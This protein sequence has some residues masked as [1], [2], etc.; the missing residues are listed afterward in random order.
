M[1]KIN[2]YN[3]C[4]VTYETLPNPISQN[5][6][7]FLLENY[8]CN[9]LYIYHPML[10]MKEG[11]KLSSGFYLYRNNKLCKSEKAFHWKFFWPLLYIKDVL[12]T[13]FWCL[14]FNQKFDIYFASGNLN[15]L[16][17]I[18]LRKLGLVRRVVY[19]SLDYYPRRFNNSFFNWLYF[20]L[21]KFCVRF[22]DE[23][24]NVNPNIVQA[25]FNKMGMDPKVFDKQYTVPGSIWFYKT[26]RLPFS[27]IN[28]NKIVYRGTL[29]DFMGIDLAIKAMP[30]ILKKFPNLIFEI[31]G[32]GIDKERLMELTRQ[33]NVSRNVIFHGFVKGRQQMEKVLSDAAIGIATFNTSICD[34]KVRNSDPGKIKDY[35][36]MG[37]P[38]IATKE[39]YYHKKIISKRCGLIIRY[40]PE[41]LA[42]AVVKLLSNSKLLKEYR[43][44]ATNFIEEYDCNNIYES[45]VVRLLS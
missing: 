30:F 36:L 11:Y 25:R 23:T 15:P 24:W 5:I 42:N 16:V 33:L 19:Q 29:L 37:M 8:N 10:D 13:L 4:V 1:K 14:R 12:Y 17:G 44:N 32:I 3:F 18:V 27:Q 39:V 45:H 43:Q 40:N 26:K 2:H 35:M 28:R 21:D 20:Q 6:M 22:S 34:D 9:I 31:V 41:E 38:V 7:T